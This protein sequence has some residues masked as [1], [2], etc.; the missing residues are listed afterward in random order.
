M[1]PAWLR[2][3]ASNGVQP[4]V[5]SM[6]T[7]SSALSLPLTAVVAPA[8]APWLAALN[9]AVWP[10][11]VTRYLVVTL[12]LGS[13]STTPKLRVLRQAVP[14]LGDVPSAGMLIR[15][16]AASRL[17]VWKKLTPLQNDTW[18]KIEPFRPSMQR[19]C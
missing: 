17:A 7:S 8:S 9:W 11:A 18:P 3:G 13:W 16:L 15:P 10:D 4:I 6:K 19:P 1:V 5:G 14:V 2:S 12:S